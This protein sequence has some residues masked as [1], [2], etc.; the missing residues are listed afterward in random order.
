VNIGV[1]PVLPE[2]GNLPA[3]LLGESSLPAVSERY[4]QAK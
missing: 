1:Y 4:P 2:R 3:G